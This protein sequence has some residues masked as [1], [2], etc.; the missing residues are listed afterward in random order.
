M[1]IQLILS[2]LGA[3]AFIAAAYLLSPK[4]IVYLISAIYI[5][6]LLYLVCFY[7]G[8]TGQSGMILKLQF[9]ILKA[10]CNCRYGLTANRSVLNMILFMPFGYLM[11]GIIKQQA[12]KRVKWWIVVLTAFVFSAL[13]ETSQMLLRFGVFESDDLIKNTAG[14]GIGYIIWIILERKQADRKAT[15][16]NDHC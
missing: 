3:A 4:P 14:A 6:L 9:P 2:L 1:Y 5:A 12:G 13:I 16:K 15:E 11:P 8:R 10:I 7:G